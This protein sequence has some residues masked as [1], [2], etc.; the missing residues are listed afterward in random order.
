ML[1]ILCVNDMFYVL[2]V[3][4]HVMCVCCTLVVC[5]HNVCFKEK[6]GIFPEGCIIRSYVPDRVTHSRADREGGRRG[7]DSE[8]AWSKKTLMVK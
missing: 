4:R 8:K 3:V 2:L 6:L 5:A 1:F 7:G